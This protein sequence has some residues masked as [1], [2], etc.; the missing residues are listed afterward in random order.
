[1]RVPLLVVLAMAFILPYPSVARSDPTEAANPVA[2]L[3]SQI[4]MQWTRETTVDAYD[5]IGN[6]D[7]KWD[8]RAQQT[9]EAAA[10]NWGK[11]PLR[12]GD[13]DMIVLSASEAAIKAGCRDP[14]VVYARARMLVLFQAEPREVAKLQEGMAQAFLASKYPAIRKCYGLLRA[15][16]VQVQAEPDN[17]KTRDAARAL[18]E[19]AM[20]M[21]PEAFAD[22]RL[23]REEVVTSLGVASDASV[24]IEGNP[25]ALR[26]RLV[27]ILEKS[28]QPK[29]AILTA[30][31]EM[32]VFDGWM[33]RGGGFANTVTPEGW[34]I[35][36]DRMAAGR[37]LLD[38]AWELDPTSFELARMQLDVETHESHGGDT[39]EKWFSTAT[40]LDPDDPRPYAAKLNWLEPKWHG[41]EEDMLAFGRECA[42]TERWSGLVPLVLVE[43]HWAVGRYGG[44]GYPPAPHREYFQRD[45]KI[46]EEIKPI[47]DRYLRE[48]N[49]SNY[50]K[51]RYAVIA[52]YSGHWKEANALFRSVKPALRPTDVLYDRDAMNALMKEAAMES[53]K[54]SEADRASR[55]AAGKLPLANDVFISARW[56]GG[57][58]WVDVTEK[59]KEW[60]SGDDDFWADN[61]TLGSDPTPGWRKHLE[62]TYK[63]AGKPRTI[64]VD[65][66]AKVPAAKL[67]P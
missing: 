7:Q 63:A 59:V 17:A 38:E 32:A 45:P 49:P 15:A 5:S 29:A 60:L 4:R 56:G 21:F 11:S 41:S 62:I 3:P 66:D 16:Q 18:V 8:G 2:T 28:I 40:K 46:W 65:E 10:R 48:P 53:R 57:N 37:A 33:A 42:A 61:D 9:L 12:N 52:A 26:D 58:N 36:H 39:M 34:R 67:K 31:G 44:D 50:H 14:L 25:S 47:Y 64:S 1:M 51:T 55:L 13:E 27:E 20:K 6:R 24:A 22:P 19:E 35:L 30:R 54:Q 23:P 43:A